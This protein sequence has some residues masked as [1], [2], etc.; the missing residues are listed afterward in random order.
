MK[1]IIKYAWYVLISGILLFGLI[2]ILIANGKIGY[3]PPIEDL[4]NPI[5]KYASQVLSADGV[6][7]GT[8][9]ME[10][11]N[12]IYINYNDLSENI[13]NALIATEDIRFYKHSGIDFYGLSRAVIKRFIFFQDAG[14]ASTISQQLAKQ[15]Y[16][17]RANSRLERLFQK[18]VEWV[19]A[20]Q[21]ERY[22]TKEEIINMY[23]N[24]FDFLHNAVG[25]QSACWVYFGKKPQD[26]SI[27]EAATLVGMCKNPS[28]YN[29]ISK[30]ERTIG[31]RNVVLSLMAKHDYITGAQG[32]SLQKLPMITRYNRVD[33]KDGSAPYFREYLRLTLTAPKPERKNYPA[34][35]KEKYREDSLAWETNP[36]YGWCN[37][38]K[39][40][41][42]SHYNLY[43]DG[44]K[45]YT[46]LNS[47]MQNY[48][49]E[50]VANHFAGGLQ[51]N[52]FKEKAKSKNAPFSSDLSTNEINKIL[53]KSIKQ[54][55]RY[56]YL[57][58]SGKS[59]TEI[60]KIFN[61]PVEMT[62]FSWAG[63]KDTIMTPLDSIKYMKSFLRTGFMVMDPRTGA[64]KAYVGGT[65]YRYFQYDMVNSGK[66]QIGST[67]K[68]FLYS[69]A[70]ES[71]ITPCDEVMH[72]E[73]VLTDELGRPY[74]PRNTVRDLIGE[75]VSVQWGLQK[76]DNWVTAFL[77]KQL[78]P[79]TLARLL[80]SYGLKSH[81]EPVVS[82]CLGPCD[83][84]V[85][86]MVSGYSA[87]VNRGI[88]IE[89]LYVTRIEDSYGNVLDTFTPQ[90]QEVITD[91]AAGK[92]LY[93]LRSV[94]DGGTGLRVRRLGFNGAMGG[95]TGT[96]QN[97]SDGWFMG[98]TPSLVG[99]VWVGGEERS[100]RFN[101][102]ADGQGATTALP[103]LADFLKKVYS[104][105]ILGY[106]VSEQFVYPESYF[107]PCR[108]SIAFED[109]LLNGP[110][111]QT[112][113]NSPDDSHSFGKLDDIFH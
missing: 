17:T 22:Y 50:A 106:S 26:V 3:M 104:D 59:E 19:I 91:D 85:S 34:W 23:L 108:S 32:D 110:D 68:P 55:D 71:G 28:Y 51:D 54:T 58:K 109:D 42:G 53:D 63:S 15:L 101:S 40:V 31:R 69:L 35:Q 99:G 39:K 57:K 103:I 70:M 9:S 92:M 100:I 76:S 96:T 67:I 48:A 16:S 87:F 94:V 78:S 64:V 14:G 29:P 65:N 66:R 73:Q 33:H 45:I 56:Y 80:H 27:E 38:R 20:V 44:L 8:Y 77:M 75:M 30:A 36:L 41:D 102:I 21:L 81:I 13:V 46:T 88:R 90:T 89:P 83:A 62:V 18:P 10:K 74:I 86:E 52:F 12:R 43:T 111:G 113:G 5:N 4:E 79:Y 98:F 84:S 72:V 105:S 93:M 25:I 82:L 95:K 47:R 2:I 60:K 11:E 61:T 112:P 97:N 49:E 7:L 24:K 1:K 37:K 6:Q 107:D